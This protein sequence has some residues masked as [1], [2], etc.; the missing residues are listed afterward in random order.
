MIEA[1][2]YHVQVK[3]LSKTRV[4]ITLVP[5]RI[6]RWLKRRVRRGVAYRAKGN[7]YYDE[8]DDSLVKGVIG[9]W[10]VATDRHVGRYVERNIEAA[11]LLS[12]E[13]MSVE[14]LLLDHPSDRKGPTS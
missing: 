7:D 3:R 9:W 8:F 14:Q 12:I 5:S 1:L 4:E 10:W 13:D 11:P 6:G 2:L